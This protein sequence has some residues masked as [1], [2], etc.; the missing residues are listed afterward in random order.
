[1]PMKSLAFV[2]PVLAPSSVS[3]IGT[4]LRALFLFVYVHPPDSRRGLKTKIKSTWSGEANIS[5]EA[6]QPLVFIA[7]GVPQW[8]QSNPPSCMQIINKIFWK[9]WVSQQLSRNSVKQREGR[10]LAPQGTYGCTAEGPACMN[11]FKL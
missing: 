11:A 1:M 2:M 6:L 5:T 4:F 9:G 10:A 3:L 7:V 8:L